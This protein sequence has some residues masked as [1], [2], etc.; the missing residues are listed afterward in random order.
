MPSSS[1]SGPLYSSIISLPSSRMPWIASQVLPR[2]G[3]SI[4]SETCSQRSPRPSVS[5]RDFSNAARRLFDQFENLFQTLDLTFG[6]AV[7]LFEGRAQL[8][9][10]G[11]LRH[12]RQCPQDLLFSEIDIL[13]SVEE[14]VVEVFRFR[15]HGATPLARDEG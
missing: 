15:G 9:G 10:T 7:M 5:P 14:Q 1:A 12:F 8:V 6:L 11:R 3:F 4:N 2:A 13:E